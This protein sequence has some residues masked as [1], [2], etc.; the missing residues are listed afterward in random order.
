MAEFYVDG[1]KDFRSALRTY[2]KKLDNE[3][4]REVRTFIKPALADARNRSRR[5]SSHIGM[6]AQVDVSNK[7]VGIRIRRGHRYGQ[8]A[9]LYERGEKGARGPQRKWRHPLFGN[10]DRW[11]DQQTKPWVYPAVAAAAPRVIRE[12]EAAVRR[13]G[14]RAGL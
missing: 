9:S 3:F 11:Y 6:A 4:R 7:G 8:L 14:M 10:R 2:D 5:A 12:L 1:I 13:F